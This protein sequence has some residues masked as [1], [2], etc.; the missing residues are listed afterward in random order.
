MQ[1]S[2]LSQ[3]T[4]PA[5]CVPL[6]PGEKAR[7]RRFPGGAAA[8]LGDTR[9]PGLWADTPSCSLSW[10]LPWT[11]RPLGGGGCSDVAF[12]WGAEGSRPEFH[13]L[14]DGR[15]DSGA[16]GLLR[17]EGSPGVAV[18]GPGALGR[19]ENPSPGWGGSPSSWASPASPVCL[20]RPRTVVASRRLS[21]QKTPSCAAF[22]I[23]PAAPP[24]HRLRLGLRW[25]LQPR[26]H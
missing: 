22:G 3:E 9:V 14:G 12:C 6:L 7:E 1:S 15:C 13:L 18:I 16:W 19:W 21:S 25:A 20:P 17:T 11:C 2:Y 4:E 26:G 8:Q 5:W 10:Q 24:A 23:G